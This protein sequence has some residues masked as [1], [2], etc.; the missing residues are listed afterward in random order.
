MVESSDIQV[1]RLFRVEKEGSKLKAFVDLSIGGCLIVKGFKV[2]QGQEG[3]FVSM[4]SQ[5]GKD[6]KWYQVALPAT[7]EKGEE[8]S[9][10]ILSA[11][12]E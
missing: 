4:P 7:K 6:G 12:R 1:A 3:L 9:E 5:P 10:L 11:Y 8:I 2:M